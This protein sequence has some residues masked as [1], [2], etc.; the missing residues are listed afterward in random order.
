MKQNLLR[1]IIPV[2]LLITITAYWHLT[3]A[4][5]QSST[6][7]AVVTKPVTTPQTVAPGTGVATVQQPQQIITQTTAITQPIQKSFT[8]KNPTDWEAI[9]YWKIPDQATQYS[10]RVPAKT[11]DG[12]KITFGPQMPSGIHYVLNK[13]GVNLDDVT[14][15]PLPQ[16][17]GT[18]IIPDEAIKRYEHRIAE[19]A[20]KIQ[21][22]Q[23]KISKES[24]KPRKG[25]RTK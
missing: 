15:V 25:P 19:A 18:F 5:P 22:E 7:A 2:T 6:T 10:D 24:S 9:V 12:K 14:I 1:V 13:D 11:M 17:G 4:Q 20:A 21:S 23:L 16:D 8:I 3:A